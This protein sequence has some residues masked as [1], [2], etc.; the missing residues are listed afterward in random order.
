MSRFITNAI[1][2]LTCGLFALW[3]FQSPSE[4]M[5]DTPPIT[6]LERSEANPVVRR[7]TPVEINIALRRERICQTDA[8]RWI[9]DAKGRKHA[10]A[11]FT[12]GGNTAYRNVS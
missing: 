5:D 6:Y 8:Q 7:S 10:V 12:A 2:F 11:S 9:V 3:L 4:A 1:F